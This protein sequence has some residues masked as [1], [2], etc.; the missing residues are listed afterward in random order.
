ML[1]LKIVMDEEKITHESRYD[2]SVLLSTLDSIF[3]NNDL[4]K[5]GDNMYAGTG[6]ADDYAKFWRIIWALAKKEW[7]MQNVKEWLWY[8]SDDGKDENDFAVE[9]ILAFCK[10]NQVGIGA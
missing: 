2:L 3:S 6:K 10:E 9:D 5:Q 1:K 4:P 8:N 7:F